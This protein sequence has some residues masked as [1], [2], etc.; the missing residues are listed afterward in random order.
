MSVLLFSV[1]R[2]LAKSTLSLIPLLGIHQMVFVF[3]LD[4]SSENSLILRFTKVAID[5]L[6]TSF[7]VGFVLAS[8]SKEEHLHRK[9]LIQLS[10]SC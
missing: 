10:A 9:A 8:S 2:R 6:V 7:Q 3:V 1:L 5:L 4:E